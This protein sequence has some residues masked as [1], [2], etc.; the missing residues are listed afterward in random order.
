MQRDLTNLVPL[1]TKVTKT[2]N[3]KTLL[4]RPHQKKNLARLKLISWKQRAAVKKKKSLCRKTK[5]ISWKQRALLFLLKKKIKQHAA[6]RALRKAPSRSS[7][8]RSSLGLSLSRSLLFFEAAC[9]CSC[10][11]NARSP[12]SSAHIFFWHFSVFFPFLYSMLLFVFYASSFTLFTFALKH[13][14]LSLAYGML[15]I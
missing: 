5:L 6:V 8:L 7:R 9:C 13:W 3:K 12:S 2:N 15:S 14:P 4:E 10:S 11:T 1:S